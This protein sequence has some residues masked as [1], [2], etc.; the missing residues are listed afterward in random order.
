MK[1]TGG[2]RMIS[3]FKLTSRSTPSEYP[4]PTSLEHSAAFGLM[5][6]MATTP[7]THLLE[8][9]TSLLIPTLS[10][11]PDPTTP[12]GLIGLALNLAKGKFYPSTP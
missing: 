1:G 2:A 9:L 4:Y 11:G 3:P 6:P 12:Y 7:R 10:P 8:K 5:L